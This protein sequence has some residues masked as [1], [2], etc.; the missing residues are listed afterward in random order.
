MAEGGGET[1]S[2]Q[3]RT[4]LQEFRDAVASIPNKPEDSDRYYLRW[5]RARQYNVQKALKMFMNVS[6]RAYSFITVLQCCNNILLL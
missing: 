3:Q 2:S 4:S 5:L 6:W 1:L